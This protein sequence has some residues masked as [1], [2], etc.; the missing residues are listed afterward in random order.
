MCLLLNTSTK[1]IKV[2]NFANSIQKEVDV[3]YHNTINDYEIF[4]LKE[5]YIANNKLRAKV[6]NTIYK[7][8]ES[9]YGILVTSSLETQSIDNNLEFKHKNR[10]VS[11]F[12]VYLNVQCLGMHFT[13]KINKINNFIDP[14]NL[15]GSAKKL[16]VFCF[17]T[18]V[19]LFDNEDIIADS[20]YIPSPKI[21]EKFLRSEYPQRHKNKINENIEEFTKIYNKLLK[22]CDKCV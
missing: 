13:Y 11:S 1:E 20:L 16:P 6:M 14:Y 18:S 9:K 2:T 10:I 22:G 7:L 5:F 17:T 4:G 12:N 8:A 3:I 15:I 19:Q 21:L